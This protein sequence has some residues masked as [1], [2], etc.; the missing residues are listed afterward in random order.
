MLQWEYT[1]LYLTADE[2]IFCTQHDPIQ[3]RV[4][5]VTYDPTTGDTSYDVLRRE[6]AALGQRGWEL[7][8]I[9]TY[10]INVSDIQQ[11]WILKRLIT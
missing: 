9:F 7:V 4:Y 3:N 2:E 8:Q 5:A 11:E 1:S 10:D 6:V